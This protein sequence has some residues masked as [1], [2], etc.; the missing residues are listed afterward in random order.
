MTLK[1][2]K[3]S[4]NAIQIENIK[5]TYLSSVFQCIS[6]LLEAGIC[7]TELKPANTLYD[8]ENGRACA[9]RFSWSY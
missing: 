2:F 9:D 3:K 8:S 7:M 1:S 5:K 4:E 6:N